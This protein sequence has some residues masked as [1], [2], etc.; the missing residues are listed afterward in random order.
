MWGKGKR[1]IALA[2]AGCLFFGGITAA[3]HPGQTL[4]AAPTDGGNMP[5]RQ[6]EYLD[7]GVV[8]VSVNNA[9]FVSWRLL[10]TDD[11]AAGFNVYRTTDGKTVKLNGDTLYQGTNFTDTTA[12]RT[13]DNTYSVR[14]M[15]NGKEEKT[16]GSYTLKGNAAQKAITI[17]IRP[18]GRIHFVWT[19]D[20]NGDGVYDFLVDRADD[21]HQKLEAYKNDGTYLWS[22]DLGYN[23]EDKN[24]IVPGAS[25]IDVGMWDGATVYDI[26]CDGYA[27]VLLR[28]ADGVTLGDGKVFQTGSANP[29]A[30]S[31]VVLD[32]Q[33][34][35]LKDSAQVPEDYINIG[36]MACMMGIGY[37][38]GI[39]PS[40][41]CFMKNRNKDKSFNCIVAPY[42][43]RNGK[44]VKEWQWNRGKQDCPDAHQIRIADVD[45]DGKDEILQIGF[46]LNGDGTLRYELGSQGVVHGDRYYVGRFSPDDKVMMGY[47]IQ[48]DNPNGL[49][50][51]AY[52][53]ATG[54]ILWKNQVAPEKTADVARGNVG[55]IDPN[56]K[57]Y[58]CWSFQGTYSYDGKLIDKE[59]PYPVLRLWWDGDLVS[60]SYNDGKIEK[61]N[62]KKKETERLE[63]TWKITDCIGSE[64][65]V[66]MFYGDILGDWREEI[67]MTSNDYSKLVILTTT[68]ETDTRLYSLAQNPA[69]RNCMTIKG[70]MQSHL[71]DY[72]LG[73]GM[74]N[75]VPP[76]ISYIEKNTGFEGVYYIKNANSKLYLDVKAASAKNGANVQQATFNGGAA[77]K[78]KIVSHGD[79]WY[80]LLTAS[81]QYKSCV[82]VEGGSA[83]DGTNVIQWGYRGGNPQCFRI[84]KN[85]DGTVA[86]LTRASNG[87]SAMEVYE[88]SKKTGA[89][90]GQWQYLGGTNQ[91][92]ILMPA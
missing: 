69:Y 55:D 7:R 86:F 85:A 45:G 42:T 68:T 71:T 22:V 4:K 27:E 43:Y 84:Q 46:C 73:T 66:P 32:G 5:V 44:F 41:V 62:Y 88:R 83:K 13:K 36:P 89:N 10:A 47:G 54:K 15:R 90:V 52:N 63:T 72:Y 9:V 92:W 25:T 29:N 65:G 31:I 75:P 23:S 38:D 80:S 59:S 79:G 67:V 3:L 34:G 57:G 16:D 40:V 6:M 87:K 20:F 21:N 81:S 12:D 39:K 24:R 91:H 33:T 30:Q 51:Y 37:L 28:A 48:Q 14:I 50:E 17:P 77:Q 53:A 76:S 58:E 19:G 64:R 82:D 35:A 60:E 11:Q 18:G 56:H 2:L 8:A 61:W 70:Y 78:F 1:N 26:D 74:K 49:L